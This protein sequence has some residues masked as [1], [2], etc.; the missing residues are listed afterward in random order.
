M[1]KIISL[2]NYFASIKFCL[3]FF[4]LKTA[5][6]RPI[7]I[8]YTVKYH[9]DKGARIEISSTL[10][11]NMVKIGIQENGY[12]QAGRSK[13][14]MGKNSKLT[15]HGKA[16]LSKGISIFIEENSSIEIGNN[17]FCNTNCLFRSTNNITLGENVLFGWDIILNTTDGHQLI[18]DNIQSKV[19]GDI[20]IGNHTWIASYSK[21]SKN[22]YIA[23]NCVIGQNS[24]INKSFKESNCLIAGIPAIIKK[25]NVIRKD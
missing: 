12:T 10:Y 6:K 14:F 25:K 20:Y 4:P 2:F 8:H 5:L 7:Q 3:H 13:I 11:S 22:V 18:I 9:I 23:D 19:S 24:L 17:F 1:N 15:F 21:I 16:I